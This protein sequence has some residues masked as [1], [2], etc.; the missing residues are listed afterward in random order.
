MTSPTLRAEDRKATKQAKPGIWLVLAVPILLGACAVPLPVTIASTVIDGISFMTTKKTIPSHGLS[1]VSGKD[2]AFY[3]G[4]MNEPICKDRDG[5]IIAFVEDWEK[6]GHPGKPATNAVSANAAPADGRLYYVLGTFAT[7]KNAKDLAGMV[8]DLS[9]S[10]IRT[11]PKGK[12]VYHVV[13]GPIGPGQKKDVQKSIASAGFYD[14]R[15]FSM[16]PVVT[17]TTSE[18]EEVALNPG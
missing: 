16:A 12:S 7:A 4:L 9:A 2:C 14:V 6:T 8:T 13:V 18:S 15:A 1:M 3:R 17:V 5:R 11:R 10:V